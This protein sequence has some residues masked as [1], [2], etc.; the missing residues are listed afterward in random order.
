MKT[1]KQSNKKCHLCEYRPTWE[2]G[3]Q[4]LIKGY[5]LLLVC[6]YHRDELLGKD[7]EEI[8]SVEDGR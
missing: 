1:V 8:R 6:D 7:W 5:V 2:M 4:T 3:K